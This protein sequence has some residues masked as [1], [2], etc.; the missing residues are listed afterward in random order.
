[1][2]RNISKEL[3]SRKT[4][5]SLTG[6][7][8]VCLCA[9]ALAAVIGIG[10]AGCKTDA[11]EDPPPPAAVVEEALRGT[12]WL[13]GTALLAFSADG[14]KAATSAG[15]GA[16]AVSAIK[17]KVE[18]APAYPSGARAITAAAK[19]GA[20]KVSNFDEGTATICTS[21]TLSGS[22]LTLTGVDSG[23]SF[24]G[25]LSAGAYTKQE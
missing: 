25:Y 6:R 24:T 8:G 3:R 19:D 9:I 16:N 20:I 11:E 1:M 7:G 14:K 4:L 22:T 18:E 2:V 21:Y 10:L 23:G 12:V 5:F 17:T 13:K 15:S